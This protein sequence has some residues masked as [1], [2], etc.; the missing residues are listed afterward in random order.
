MYGREKVK[1][2][3]Y[4]FITII[5]MRVIVV[6]YTW[7]DNHLEYCSIFVRNM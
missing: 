1:L 6:Y 7:N 3:L 2:F 5:V 4:Y